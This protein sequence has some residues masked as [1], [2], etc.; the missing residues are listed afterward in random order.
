MTDQP[1]RLA[2][3]VV[4]GYRGRYEVDLVLAPTRAAEFIDPGTVWSSGETFDISG[5]MVSPG[6]IETQINGAYGMDFTEEPES[7]WS[8]GQRLGEHGVT[9]FLPTLVSPTDA[10][11]SKAQ[12]V[13]EGGPPSGYFG[14]DALGLHI[15]GPFISRHQ[16]GAHPV[17]RLAEPGDI[18]T[19]SW[20][21]AAGVAMVTLAPELPGTLDLTT[22]L[23]G[24]GVVVAAGHTTATFEI[25]VLAAARG[26]KHATHLFNGMTRGNHRDPGLAGFYL[27]TE[28][29]TASFIGD[30]VHTHPS[31]CGLVW[32]CLGPGRLVLVSDA[33]SAM[34]LPAGTYSLGGEVVAFDGTRVRSRGGSLAGSAVATDRV[35]RRFA[36]YSR[37]EISEV[38]P[39]LTRTP[40][41]VLGD[42]GRGSVAAGGRGDV[43]VLEP[44]GEVTMTFVDGRM[45]YNRPSSGA[46]L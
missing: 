42:P 40:A 15:E 19:S 17:D 10:M 25:A 13:L 21:R 9:A 37:C 24:R 8:V 6:F 45:V 27:T 32:R 16:P 20:A 12:G 36:S 26:I 29:V 18:D 11:V 43:V 2:G 41:S 44:T 5:R 46:T 14:A 39:T 33:T 22:E 7:I 28:G 3:G 35:F 38:L 34:G 4:V 31:V 1:I 30:G 23:M